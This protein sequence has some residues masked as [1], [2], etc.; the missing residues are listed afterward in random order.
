MR[1]ET[2]QNSDPSTPSTPRL[3]AAKADMMAKTARCQA[4]TEDREALLFSGMRANLLMPHPIYIASGDGAHITDIDGNEYIDT[5]MGFGACVLGHRHPD[6]ARA[7]QRVSGAGWHFGIHS[8]EQMPLAE[9]LHEAIPCAERILFCNTGSEATA[10]AMRAA[11]TFAGKEKVGI[12]DGYWHGMHDY[13][14]VTPAR[15]GTNTRP[16]GQDISAGVPKAIHDLTVPLAYRNRVSLDII[17]EKKDE[18]A[19][20]LIE[21]VQHSNPQPDVVDFLRE[22]Q[23]VC[24]ECGVLFLLDEMVTGFR[25]AYGGGQ[26][27]FGLTPDLATLGKACGGGL[28]IGVV[29]GREDIMRTFVGDDGTTP[30]VFAGGTFT[31]NPMSMAAG[32]ASV[33]YMRDH[34]EIYGHMEEQGNRLTAAFNSHCTQHN[35]PLHM[36]NVGSM[37]HIYFQGNPVYSSFDIDEQPLAAAKQAFC[38]HALNLGVLISGGDKYYLSAAHTAEHVDRMIDIFTETLSLV[39][40]DGLL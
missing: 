29:A 5:V 22:V 27:R 35:M 34:R 11:R 18:L 23:D 39:R 19:V 40:E 33:A 12:F 38:L 16:K 28:P 31:G 2:M 1:H 14:M 37:F 8:H 3:D 32:A 6:V 13:C 36:S 26:E 20:V 30:P 17:R 9:M 10:Y 15:D 25:I 4:M 7:I 24:R 21:P